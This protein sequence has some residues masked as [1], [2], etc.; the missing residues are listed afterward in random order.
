MSKMTVRGRIII[1]FSVVVIVM[2]IAAFIWVFYG[3]EAIELGVFGEIEAFELE[4]V[5]A[6]STYQSDNGKIK[7]LSF[8]FINC[9]DGVCPMTMVD[10]AYIQEV[11]KEEE[12][13]GTDVELVAITFDPIRDTTEALQEYAGYFDVDPSGWKFLRGAEEDIQ[14]VADELKYFYHL[15]EDGSGMHSTTMYI[16]D[17]QHQVRAYHKMSSSTESM[18]KEHIIRDL[19]LLVDEKNS[20]R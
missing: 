2:T 11:L 5:I 17:E 1:F 16:I 4:D 3:N 6:E 20:G 12:L 18:D 10:Y 15:Q 7:L 14:A 9:P 19:K 8:I 13:F